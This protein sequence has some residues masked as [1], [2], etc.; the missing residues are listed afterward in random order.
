[1]M[2]S[3]GWLI[4]LIVLAS[5]ASIRAG[6]TTCMFGRKIGRVNAFN[7]GIF[8]GIWTISLEFWMARKMLNPRITKHLKTLLENGLTFLLSMIFWRQA[9]N[10]FTTKIFPRHRV[11]V[12]SSKMFAFWPKVLANNWKMMNC[13][14]S[15]RSC[16]FG[17][18]SAR[19]IS[20]ALNFDQNESGES[21]ID[22]EHEDDKNAVTYAKCRTEM[23][24]VKLRQTKAGGNRSNH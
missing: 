15:S 21:G 5:R 2:N 4:V 13:V 18:R 17:E 19:S 8:Y 9:S 7:S 12:R 6:R 24:L 20:H 16:M 11:S 22:S 14:S 23:K 10:I 3:N 1:M